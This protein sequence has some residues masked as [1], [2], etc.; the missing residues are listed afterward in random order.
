MADF[1][2]GSALVEATSGKWYRLAKGHRP[3]TML[4]DLPNKILLGIHISSGMFEIFIPD[5]ENIY[6]GAGDISFKI[7]NGKAT[8]HLFSTALEEIQLD[9]NGSKIFN[10]FSDVTSLFATL[11][12]ENTKQ[13]QEK[14]ITQD[15]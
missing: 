1:P 9:T 3:G 10:T 8:V 7:E 11:N 6:H 5:D 13:W 15:F 12:L 14:R 2:D 4:L